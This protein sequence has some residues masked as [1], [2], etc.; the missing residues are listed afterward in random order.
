MIGTQARL[1]NCER[2]PLQRYGLTVFAH[3]CMQLCEI[4][5]GNCRTWVLWTE[6]LFADLDGSLGERQRLRI[7]ATLLVEQ[8]QAA[9]TRGNR[10]ALKSERLGV[11]SERA[12]QQRQRVVRP[13]HRDVLGGQIAEADGGGRMVGAEHLLVY[14]DGALL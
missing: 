3:R 8:R 6:R 5:Q 2:A 9:G 7:V 1:A 11:N 4:I 13:V 12:L 14:G 10:R